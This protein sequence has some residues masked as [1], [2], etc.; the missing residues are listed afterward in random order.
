MGWAER[1][2]PKSLLNT[3]VR[4]ER[5]AKMAN[6]ITRS[7]KRFGRGLVAVIIAGALAYSSKDPKW[8]I[9]APVLQA[10]AKFLRDKFGI[11]YLPL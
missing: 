6:A 9:F 11:K 5:Q 2:N 8:L 10:V 7:I 3:I 1:A 4:K